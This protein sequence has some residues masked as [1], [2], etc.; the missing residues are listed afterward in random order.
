MA[1]ER[2]VQQHGVKRSAVAVT[3]ASAANSA[4][5]EVA[6][7]DAKRGEPTAP[8]GDAAA[9]NGRIA[10]SLDREEADAETIREVFKEFGAADIR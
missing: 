9:L 6:S 8:T 7:A 2:L 5:I 3:P 4:G 1:I 10:V